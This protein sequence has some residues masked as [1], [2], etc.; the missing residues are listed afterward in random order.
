M[1]TKVLGKTGAPIKARAMMYQ[2]VVQAVLL[3]GS[4]IWLVTDLMMAV[5]ELFRHRI[6]IRI[7][8]MTER[9]VNGG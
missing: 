3:Y 2:L 5:I 9:K 6:A 8:G 4:K 1:V 7:A